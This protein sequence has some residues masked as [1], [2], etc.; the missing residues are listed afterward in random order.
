MRVFARWRTPRQAYPLNNKL[1]C[2]AFRVRSER[3]NK[4]GLQNTDSVSACISSPVNHL[5]RQDQAKAAQICAV[6]FIISRHSTVWN[7]TLYTSTD[8]HHMDKYT[9][10]QNEGTKNQNLYT[11]YDTTHSPTMTYTHDIHTHIPK[12]TKYD[13]ASSLRPWKLR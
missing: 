6:L 12:L 5:R 3:N 11:T 1:G 4:K 7:G 2:I 8:M 9:Y 13:W 10:T